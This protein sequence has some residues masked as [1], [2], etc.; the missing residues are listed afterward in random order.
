MVERNSV[1]YKVG[2]VIQTGTKK[3]ETPEFALIKNIF[4]QEK[5]IFLGCQSLI[6]L[7]FSTHFHAFRVEKEKFL[8]V[9]QTNPKYVKSSFI[10][11]GVNQNNYVMWD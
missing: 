5:N 6:V 7:G 3:D 11:C 4:V 8:F 9:K 1:V 10:F 2:Y